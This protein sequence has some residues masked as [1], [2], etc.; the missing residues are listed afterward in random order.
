VNN[1]SWGRF[2]PEPVPHWVAYQS[3]ESGQNEVYVDSFPNRRRAVRISTGG[4][5]YPQWGS[6][7]GDRGEL[8]Y[9]SADSH[10]MAAE[11]SLKDGQVD[12]VGTKELF[13]LAPGEILAG[14]SPYDTAH[15]GQRFLIRTPVDAVRSLTVLEN[16]PARLAASSS[17]R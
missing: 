11:L 1:E 15:D 17:T 8:F 10:L 7:R 6:I 5:T 4:G 12:V 3:D 13:V 14:Y 2:S 16:W 9:V